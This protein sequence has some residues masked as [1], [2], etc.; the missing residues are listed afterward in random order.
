V[1]DAF[2]PTTTEREPR[3]F[4]IAAGRT[5]T[6]PWPAHHF[7]VLVGNPPWDEPVG[8]AVSSTAERWAAASELPVGD[9]SPSQLFLWLALHLLKADGVA[10]LLV[11]AS[12]FYNTRTTSRAFRRTWL[13]IVNLEEVANFSQVRRLFFARAVAPFCF[14]RF[15]V[16]GKVTAASRVLFSTVRPSIPLRATKALAYGQ[17]ERRVV[18]QAALIEREYLWKVYAWGNHHDEA[19][20][21]RLDLEQTLADVLPSSTRP[22]YGYQRGRTR[23]SQTLLDVPSLDTFEPW[24][25][26]LPSWLEPPPAGV[27]RQPDERLYEG[28]RLLVR[29][30]IKVGFGPLVRLEDARLAFRHTTYCIPLNSLPV[31]QAM[32]LFGILLSSLG[33]Y[34]IFMT[35]GSWG[36][37]H[38]SVVSQDILQVPVRVAARKDPT[39]ARLLT[40]VRAIRAWRPESGGSSAWAD[41]DPGVPSGLLGE[42]N[43]AVFD[44]FGLTAGERDI[45]NDWERYRVP[46]AR[47]EG[48]ARPVV[49]QANLDASSVNGNPIG[50]YIDTF[51]GN[52]NRELA[53]EAQLTW[54]LATSSSRTVLAAIFETRE[55]SLPTSEDRSLPR[56][57]AAGWAETLDRLDTTLQNQ[58][59]RRIAIDGVVRSVADTH[60]VIVKRNEERLWSASAA[61]EDFEATLV[62]AMNLRQS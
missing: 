48:A 8:S 6:L 12:V 18:S 43:D 13:G 39:V 5:S 58:L 59:A 4:E 14:V 53:P 15:R 35:S 60:I 25:P 54:R 61:R 47:V 23:P 27:K 34:R 19:L 36:L 50:R 17:V 55:V 11:A 56:T 62:Q 49:P 28:Y 52:W 41:G 32:L 20:M 9:R 31:W 3:L 42:L 21:S 37:W 22:G 26:V 38:D 2:S 30:G 16:G 7:D 10:G 46:G 45:V 1:A 51:V 33:R 44:L 24:G 57:S 29:R 40:I